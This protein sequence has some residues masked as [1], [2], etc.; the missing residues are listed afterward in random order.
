MKI[1]F[2]LKNS[3]LILEQVS[4]MGK[5]N[6]RSDA[7]RR[8]DRPPSNPPLVAAFFYFLGIAFPDGSLVKKLFE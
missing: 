6:L 1:W 2:F 4:T 5:L 3:H 7:W 8:P